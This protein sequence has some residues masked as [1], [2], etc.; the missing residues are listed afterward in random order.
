MRGNEAVTSES[1]K[2]YF[3]LFDAGWNEVCFIVQHLWTNMPRIGGHTYLA[4]V[5]K[6][7]R[8]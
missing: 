5:I 3:I 7:V 4:T 2:G 1:I 6:M 8:E